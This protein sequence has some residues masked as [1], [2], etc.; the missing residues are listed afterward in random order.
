ML[1]QFAA[2]VEL[3]ASA[4]MSCGA[5]RNS[6]GLKILTQSPSPPGRGQC[7]MSDSMGSVRRHANHVLGKV[8]LSLSDHEFLKTGGNSLHC[9]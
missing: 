8:F 3:P 5:M 2:H 9:D 4:G 1:D 6:G 7:W